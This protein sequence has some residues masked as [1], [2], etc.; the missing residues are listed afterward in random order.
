MNKTIIRNINNTVGKNDILFLLGDISMRPEGNQ[1]LGYLECRTRIALGNHDTND[2]RR[3]DSF[4]ITDVHMGFEVKINNQRGIM[5]HIPI[6]PAC[7]TRWSFN[8][9]GHLHY[10]RIERYVQPESAGHYQDGYD[11][12]YHCV[13]VEQINYTPV[14]LESLI[15]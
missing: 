4:G 8:I 12:R 3:F 1:W 6:H 5:T 14:L 13:S 15:K 11:P 7:L 2:A 10:H 9:H